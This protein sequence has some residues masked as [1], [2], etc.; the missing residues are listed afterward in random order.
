MGL[1]VGSSTHFLLE[2]WHHQILLFQISCSSSVSIHEHGRVRLLGRVWLCPTPWTV[3]CQSPLFMGFFRQEYWS[4]LPFPSLGDLP[5][6]G[7]KPV[8]LAS[9]ALAGG[10]FTTEPHGKPVSIHKLYQLLRCGAQGI[11]QKPWRTDFVAEEGPQW[12]QHRFQGSTGAQC[13]DG[14]CRG[15]S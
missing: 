8:S 14:Q 7:I 13:W 11:K 10:C 3:A 2:D 9:S 1:L 5:D 6:S 12:Q 15:I 4:G